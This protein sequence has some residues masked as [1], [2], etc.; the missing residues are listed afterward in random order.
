MRALFRAVRRSI[1]LKL[2][3]TLVGFVAIS[4]LVAGLYLS[5]AL[6]SFAVESLET[7]LASVAAVLE[8]EARLL[9]RAE[10]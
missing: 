6:E 10:A 3:L 9:L 2:T 5:R 1:A 4:S 7:R 8:D